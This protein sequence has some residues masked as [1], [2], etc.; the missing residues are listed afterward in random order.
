MEQVAVPEGSEDYHEAMIVPDCPGPGLLAL[1]KKVVG[2]GRSGCL[3]S[4]ETQKVTLWNTSQ[5]YG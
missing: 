5:R 3:S 4:N 2:V 1:G